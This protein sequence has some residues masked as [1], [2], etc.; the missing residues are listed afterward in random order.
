VIGDRS[1]GQLG[2]RRLEVDSPLTD[3]R[4]D[5][6]G[7]LG[8]IGVEAEADLTAALFDE[9]RESIREIGQGPSL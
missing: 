6:A 3:W 8:R 2:S 5:R 4:G 7:Q 1:G 9:R